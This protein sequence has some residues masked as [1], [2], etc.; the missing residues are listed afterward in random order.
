MNIKFFLQT[1][2]FFQKLDDSQLT[3]LVECGE[4]LKYGLSQVLFFPEEE[5]G[6]L[7]L[8]LEGNVRI[9]GKGANSEMSEIILKPGHIFCESSLLVPSPQNATAKAITNCKLFLL[10]RNAFLEILKP[11][12]DFVLNLLAGLQLKLEQNK[13][14]FYQEI[15]AKLELQYQSEFTRYQTISQFVS[16]LVHQITP[17]LGVVNLNS[18][19]I[20]KELIPEQ[21]TSITTETQHQK[22]L[23]KIAENVMLI[24]KQ[25]DKMNELL[26]AFKKTVLVHA[27]QDKE[28]VELIATL[29][30]IVALYRASKKEVSL[31]EIEI[32]SLVADSSIKWLGYSGY[33]SQILFHLFQNIEQH[34]YSEGE[35][36]RLKMWV[37]QE[38]GKPVEPQK[39]EGVTQFLNTLNFED[40][41]EQVFYTLIL[42]DYGKGMAPEVL[43]RV[44]E[45]FFT[46]L[47]DS[48][49][50]GLGLTLVYNLITS[51]FKGTLGIQSREKQGT[52]V[53]LT[54]PQ[55]I[56]DF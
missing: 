17:Y 45:P 37:S 43:Q 22:T 48:K 49:N 4:T 3:Q 29:Q 53:T 47:P 38:K 24:Q 51:G 10:R 6:C 20:R 36:R 52:T 26:L 35:V 44:F 42:R 25:V 39:Q 7:Y 41:Q 14:R 13:S 12:F 30:E 40:V 19:L 2:S 15:R 8:I 1:V 23:T 27:V 56:P 28:E 34:A 31:W 18:K 33:L 55:Q 50:T 46:T 21:I 32:E 54:F 11:S 9:V 5:V 16:G